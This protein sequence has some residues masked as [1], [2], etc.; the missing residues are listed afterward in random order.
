MDSFTP[1]RPPVD[2]APYDPDRFTA[3]FAG[4]VAEVRVESRQLD[5]TGIEVLRDE[6]VRRYNAF[7]ELVGVLQDIHTHTDD[8]D[9]SMLLAANVLNKYELHDIYEHDIEP[10]EMTAEEAAEQ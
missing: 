10:V 5:I 2:L 9:Y 4:D 7:E 3:E 6:L 8:R 1:T